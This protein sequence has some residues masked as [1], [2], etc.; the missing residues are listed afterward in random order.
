MK[1]SMALTLPFLW[2]IYSSNIWRTKLGSLCAS[3][4]EPYPSQISSRS[5]RFV[6]DNS[7]TLRGFFACGMAHLSFPCPGLYYAF[8]RSKNIDVNV[9]Y[10]C[11]PY[12]IFKRRVPFLVKLYDF[13]PK[14]THKIPKY[15]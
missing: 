3:L 9:K 15:K 2:L 5:R 12:L 11:Y 4:R 6:L 7:T 14:Q 13:L 1:E 8:C 10:A